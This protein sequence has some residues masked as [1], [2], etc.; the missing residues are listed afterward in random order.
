MIIKIPTNGS[1]VVTD[2]LS[3][4]PVEVE[5]KIRTSST[6]RAMEGYGVIDL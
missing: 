6:G 4:A 3:R 1:T 2:T 5:A